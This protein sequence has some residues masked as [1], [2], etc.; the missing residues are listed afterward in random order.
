[1]RAK[2]SVKSWVIEGQMCSGDLLRE[3]DDEDVVSEISASP[4]WLVVRW[5]WVWLMSQGFGMNWDK[6]EHVCVV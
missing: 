2:P 1:M 3:E 5:R 6:M 4:L